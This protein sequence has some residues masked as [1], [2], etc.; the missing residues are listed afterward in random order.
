MLQPCA[1]PGMLACRKASHRLS[2]TSAQSRHMCH[3]FLLPWR[4]MNYPSDCRTG[5]TGFQIH[6]FGFGGLEI[7]MMRRVWMPLLLAVLAAVLL[8]GSLP[9]APQVTL[10]AGTVYYVDVTGNDASPGTAVQ[11]WRT[12]QKAANSVNPGDTVIVRSGTYSERVRITRSGSPG[13]GITFETQGAVQTQGFTV[14]NADYITI[15][16]FQTT[17]NVCDYT[18]GVGIFVEGGDYCL[19]ED[20]YAYYNPRGG[21]T[22]F[23][24]TGCVVRN[25]RLHRNARMGIEVGGSSNLVEDNEIW[26]TIQ[27]HPETSC[28]SDADGMRFF[29]TNQII[30]SN[31]IH[32]ISY[33]DP[34]V[35][36]AHID[37]FQTWNYSDQGGPGRNTTFENN[38][39][40][41]L[42]AQSSNE[43][44]QGFMIEG[45]S[46]D[47]VIRNNIIRAYRG[48]NAWDASNLFIAN[49]TLV[50]SLALSGSYSPQGVGLNN[51][52]NALVR[53]NIFYDQHGK[54]IL[55]NGSSA[56]GL[57]AGHNLVYRSDGVMPQG[58]PYPDDLWQVDP[59]FVDLPGGDFHLSAT[60]PAIDAAMILAGV[61]ADFDG[62]ARPIGP[63]HDM[64]VFEHG[65]PL[66]ATLAYFSAQ[67]AGDGVMLTWETVSELDVL[68]F[69]LYDAA[70]TGGP[71]TRLNPQLIPS[72]S[73]GS[74]AGAT[75]RWYE[76]DVTLGSA[77]WYRLESVSSDGQAI[78]IGATSLTSGVPT[79]RAWL[80]TILE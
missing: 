43:T 70:S 79:A 76:A 22:L 47:L 58:S 66:A 1:M 46:G 14:A 26:E 25:N 33:A 18:R 36:N 49:N 60:S 62:I 7:T 4:A 78:V 44:G 68:G 54:I 5:W 56:Q 20:N 11:P 29:G 80:P 63:S 75:Y 55:V 3:L 32:S 17:S 6:P 34:L 59:R 52:P 39:C 74:S 8:S 30:R 57:S 12:I 69:N 16:G 37:C 50:N 53:N 9:M 61:P 19:L 38:F 27:R 72:Q 28:S 64:G 65:S 67:A 35:D 23:N 41:V 13:L 21:I 40:D 10:A 31:H 77:R 24:T 51:S 73:P 2:A 48:V 15:R 71:W 45:G 42:T